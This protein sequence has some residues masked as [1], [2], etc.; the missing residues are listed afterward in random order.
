MGCEAANTTGTGQDLLAG[1]KEYNNEAPA[2]KKRRVMP[3]EFRLQIQIFA[4]SVIIV[5][6]RELQR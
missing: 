5:D 4:L 3:H 1:S 6:R 2:S